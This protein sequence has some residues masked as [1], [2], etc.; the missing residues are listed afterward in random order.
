MEGLDQEPSVTTRRLTDLAKLWGRIKYFH[1]SL[2]YQTDLD[3][4]AAL[5]TTI[6]KVR[7][8]RTRGEYQAALQAMLD[9]IGDPLTRILSV[10]NPGEARNVGDEKKLSYF[11]SE[12]SVLVITVGD[13]YSL[14]N[15]DSQRTLTEIVAAVAKA[16]AVIFDL[17]SSQ[18]TDAYGRFQ[19]A[20]NLR[21]VEQLM[22]TRTL[23]TPGERRRVYYGFESQ[24]PFAS[25]QYRSGFFTQDGRRLTPAR[26]ARNLPSVFVLNKHAGILESAPTLQA[27][28][29]SL[30]VFEGDVREMAIGRY[31][32][33][34]LSDG[35]SA[36]IRVSEPVHEDG[37]SARVQPDAVVAPG[38]DGRPDAALAAAM[39]LIR[40]FRPTT[41]TRTVVP[42]VA[43]A[44][45][46]KSY[47]DMLYPAPEYRLLAAFRFWNTI[48]YFF[49][50]K[51]LMDQDWN[52]VLPEFISKFESAENAMEYTRAVSEMAARLQ[53]SHA[54]VA[55]RVY[56]N[57]L[58]G[59]GY[60]P[61]RVRLIEGVPIVTSLTNE[62]IARAA[63]VEVGDAVLK[64]DGEDASERLARYATYFSASTPQSL[65]DKAAI[66]FMNGPLDVPV[67]LILRNR[68]NEEIIVTLKRQFEDF[69]TLYHRER[70]GDIVRILPGN[71]G[72]VDLDRLTYQSVNGMFEQLKNTRA[73]VFDMRG[74][75]NG[76]FTAIGPRLTGK[77]GVI[78]F[79]ETPI[80]GHGSPAA[81]A[82]ED[83]CQTIDPTPPGK[84]LYRGKTVM[85]MDERT[86]SQAEHTGLV[87]RA[88]NGTT[89][90]G[91]RT[92]GANGEVTVL[93]LPGGLAVGFTGQSVKFP[94]GR[95]LQ[96]VG[97]VPDIE[98]KPTIRGIQDGRDEILEQA[99]QY[100]QRTLGN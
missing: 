74:Y 1:P 77:Q 4:D 56:S 24:S 15:A 13:Y 62:A 41:V 9:M 68:A 8:A 78:A 59:N 63:G 58:I 99:L 35:L 27:L 3:W 14:T 80:V 32:M 65:L 98:I 21:K 88:A 7:S 75:P 2:G 47:S 82:S 5:V 61:I 42:S 94:E 22:S 72:Y 40:R 10:G 73:I 26:N 85:L 86:Q 19:L 43:S 91:S 12:G 37:T 45:P 20:V 18:P 39:A 46:E 97:L 17:R 49:P 89:F 48:Q 33:I 11:V 53:D 70:S 38:V 95:Q 28:G 36:R 55:G 57:E 6:P 81:P 92:A 64:V 31:E 50:Y 30:I 69:T 66:Y 84:W 90:I 44:M 60:P 76:T 51:H 71:I 34:D 54:Y 79:F 52:A 23:V 83:F 25:G 29:Q 87:L 100:L 93:T 67:R 16:R 96:R